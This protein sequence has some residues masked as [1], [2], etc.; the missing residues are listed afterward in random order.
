[1]NR[2]TPRDAMAIPIAAGLALTV[3]PAAP[4]GAGERYPAKVL[5]GKQ[6]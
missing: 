4:T 2:A 1:M 6:L 5:S 3:W